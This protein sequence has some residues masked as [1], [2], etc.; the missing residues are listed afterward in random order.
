MG[1]LFLCPPPQYLHTEVLHLQIYPSLFKQL[2]SGMA[3][4][5]KEGEMKRFSWIIIST[6]LLGVGCGASNSDLNLEGQTFS[7]LPVAR[8]GDGRGDPTCPMGVCVLPPSPEQLQ[9]A[10]AANL[11]DEVNSSNSVT[12]TWI[13]DDPNNVVSFVSIYGR[14][15]GSGSFQLYGEVFPGTT[16]FQVNSVLQAATI[17]EFYVQAWNDPSQCSSVHGIGFDSLIVSIET[18]RAIRRTQ[19]STP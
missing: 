1:V 9:I 5:F 15:A 18:S 3:I 14:E 4:A 6:F 7:K 17:Y 2:T 13:M 10:L 16:M 12:L 11:I 8:V 19:G